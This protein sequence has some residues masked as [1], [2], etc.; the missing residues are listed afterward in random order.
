MTHLR[1]WTVV[2]G[3]DNLNYPSKIQGLV[4]LLNNIQED[5]KTK[6]LVFSIGERGK[7][8]S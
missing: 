7:M 1:L 5:L 8:M 3:A 2:R 6:N 4:L